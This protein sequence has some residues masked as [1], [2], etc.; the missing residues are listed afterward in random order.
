MNVGVQARELK[1]TKDVGCQ[2]S[3]P[4]CTDVGVQCD[5]TMQLYA[6]SESELSDVTEI[7]QESSFIVSDESLS[8]L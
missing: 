5:M 8:P 1:E 6:T 2:C 3:P 7:N 4:L